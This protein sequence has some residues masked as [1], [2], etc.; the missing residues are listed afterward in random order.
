MSKRDDIE[1]LVGQLLDL[2][3][4]WRA[5]PDDLMADAL[6]DLTSTL[7][8]LDPESPWT[9]AESEAIDDRLRRAWQLTEDRADVVR[10]QCQTTGQAQV[11]AV[12]VRPNSEFW[13]R[14][15]P[16]QS[17][18][19]GWPTSPHWYVE[20]VTPDGEVETVTG[21]DVT[22]WVE[23]LAEVVAQETAW[24]QRVAQ[25]AAQWRRGIEHAASEVRR[26]ERALSEA[27]RVRDEAIRAALAEGMRAQDAMTASGLSQAR[28]YQLR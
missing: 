15:G 16:E 24:R 11:G 3:P 7:P 13:D 25:Q 26:A 5:I 22:S 14:R 28:V 20:L 12:L 4:A 23:L 9:E 8:D 6:D 1:T 17:A 27:Q 2:E 19:R 21:G 18:M 10:R